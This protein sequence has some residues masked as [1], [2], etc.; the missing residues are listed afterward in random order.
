MLVIYLFSVGLVGTRCTPMTC[1]S[2]SGVQHGQNLIIEH[3]NFQ[4]NGQLAV[5]FLNGG[6]LPE[7]LAGAQYS[8]C[9]QNF[10]SCVQGTMSGACN[11]VSL[12][13]DATCEGTIMV[14]LPSLNLGTPCTLK[15]VIQNQGAFNY[16]IAYGGYA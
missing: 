1:S 10:S 7:N 15:V 8:V 3:Y 11:T 16:E 14:S 13:V 5:M 2:Q 12:G 9:P 6:A 4:T